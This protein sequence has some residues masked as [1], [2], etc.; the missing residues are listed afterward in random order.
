MNPKTPPAAAPDSPIA[1]LPKYWADEHA[2]RRFVDDLF[3][4]S[5]HDYDRFERILALGTG[6]R[7][8]RD[9]LRRSGL[10]PG[11]R[12][13][14]IATGTGLVARE[15]LAL[16][17]EQG[18]VIGLDPS[19]GMLVE[20]HC[21]LPIPLVR[22][23]G[24]RI[25]CRDA[26]FDFVSMGFALRHVADLG[27]LFR[28]IRRVLRPGG[29]ACIL[30]ITRPA[31]PLAAEAVRVFMTRVMPVFAGRASRRAEARKLMNFYW[32]TINA[33]VRPEAVL[34][35]LAGAGFD[36]PRRAVVLRLFS[37][38]VATAPSAL[39]PASDIHR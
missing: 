9:A 22:A 28:E 3:D 10:R 15:A 20:A 37:E 7:Y 27:L 11:M 17:G 19:A 16:V 21:A 33:C 36:A 1:A 6:S 39:A 8:R 5:A 2:R 38:Y 34:A 14:D 29:T 26:S 4:H 31:S 12:V 30:E 24:E 35:A 32:D 25:P 18:G 13:L 23:F